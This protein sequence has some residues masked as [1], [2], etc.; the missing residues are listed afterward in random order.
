MNFSSLKIEIGETRL[1]A[2]KNLEKGRYITTFNNKSSDTIRGKKK[3]KRGQKE[4]NCRIVISQSGH[5]SRLFYS[6]YLPLICDAR[7]RYSVQRVARLISR[8][9]E[10]VGTKLILLRSQRRLSNETTSRPLC[11][12]EELKK[13]GSSSREQKFMNP[14]IKHL[15]VAD[16]LL[17]VLFHPDERISFPLRYLH[18]NK[19]LIRINIY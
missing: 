4:T 13:Q 9:I 12:P 6:S 7:T 10:V 3:K 15:F 11:V 2:I 8:V 16:V 17:A 14:P 18:A 1:S 5:V 19:T